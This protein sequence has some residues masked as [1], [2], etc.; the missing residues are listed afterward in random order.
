MALTLLIVRYAGRERPS[1]LSKR[2]DRLGGTIGRVLSNALVLP[3]PLQQISKTHARIDF[4]NGAYFVTHL[5]KNPT[6]L[7]GT[8]LDG[9]RPERL[10]NGDRLTIGEY[11]IRVEI[12]SAGSTGVP[13]EPHMRSARAIDPVRHDIPLRP[14]EPMFG[15]TPSFLGVALS[16]E[17]GDDAETSEARPEWDAAQEPQ[18]HA[19]ARE[20][21]DDQASSPTPPSHPASA[22]RSL[23]NYNPLTDSEDNGA[24]QEAVPT[25]APSTTGSDTYP[26]GAESLDPHTATDLRASIAHV[27]VVSAISQPTLS[28]PTQAHAA[29]E[30]SETDIRRQTVVAFLEAAGVPDLWRKVE[31]PTSFMHEAGKLFREAIEGLQRV[32]MSRAMLKRELRVEATMIAAV[33]NNPIKA[34][35]NARELLLYLFS[36]QERSGYLPPLQAVHD[37]YED[38]EMHNAAVIAGMRNALKKVLELFDPTTIE[39]RVRRGS[40]LDKVLPGQRKA[41]MWDLLSELHHQ[42]C[43]EAED[44]FDRHF[45]AAFAKAYEREV[46]RLRSEKHS[47]SA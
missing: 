22:R 35:P 34:L 37:G 16:G 46:N 33:E 10:S 4:W 3:D 19:P 2:F 23:K 38:L 41:R 29:P 21:M 27:E 30:L 24:A 36:P 31:D 39:N 44:D 5:G 13:G 9:N 15:G 7:N 12:E 17:V 45:G 40:L 28:S 18:H 43:Q 20:K 47:R 26:V 14:G 8:V 11:E 25:S 1:A 42:V 32:L 6:E